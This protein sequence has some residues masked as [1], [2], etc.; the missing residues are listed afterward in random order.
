[1]QFLLFW[2]SRKIAFKPLVYHSKI[3]YIIDNNDKIFSLITHKTGA[4][5]HFNIWET[6]NEWFIRSF[7]TLKQPILYDHR[8]SKCYSIRERI[9]QFFSFLFYGRGAYKVLD[10]RITVYFFEN[11]RNTVIKYLYIFSIRNCISTVTPGD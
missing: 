8:V 2:R 10:Y 5:N 1:M 4:K 9:Q 3:G 7:C 11:H 6:F